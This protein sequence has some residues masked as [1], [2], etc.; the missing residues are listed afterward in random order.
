M[1]EETSEEQLLEFLY[2]CPVGLIGCD[3]A[4]EIQMINPHA[5]QLILPLSGPNNAQ[6]LFAALER[7]APELRNMAQRFSRE[8]GRIC[9]GHRV[10]V[11]LGA[12]RKNAEPKV[13][14]CTIVKLGT[15]RLMA[16]LTDISAQVAQERRLREADAWFASLVDGINDYAVLT[17]SSKGIIEAANES[18]TRQTGHQWTEV[19]GKPLVAVMDVELFG[20]PKELE[21]DLA[22]AARDGWHLHEGAQVGRDGERYWC[23]RLIVP[24]DDHSDVAPA[25]FSVVLRNVSRRQKS[26]EDLRR[27]L[28]CD[29]LTGAANRLSFR[30]TLER[31]RERWSQVREPLALIYLDLDHFKAIND[32][33]GHPTGDI[34]LCRLVEVCTPRLPPGAL[35]A[36]LGGEEFGLL[37]PRLGLDQAVS[38]AETLREA[39]SE[40]VITTATGDV[41]VTASFGCATLDQAKGSADT[42]IDLADKALYAAKREG[43][44]CVLATAA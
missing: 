40:I 7:H 21:A 31:E 41:H 20:T 4:G 25:G 29:H 30:Q 27:L 11:D 12:G 39:I 28:T 1:V 43:R 17:V 8:T 16:T 13:M 15:N 32:A 10:F 37:L 34:V 36:R 33:H 19:V 5:M 26:T 14:S 18:F 9:E 6:N 22:R 23:Q 2:A 3:V 38:L 24:R 44:N 35:L 42:L